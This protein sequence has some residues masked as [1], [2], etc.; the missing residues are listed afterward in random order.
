MHDDFDDSLTIITRFE[1]R[2][3]SKQLPN[4]AF[5]TSIHGNSTS[6]PPSLIIFLS[7]SFGR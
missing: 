5:K 3:F 6:S 2:P 1:S 4:H 7:K